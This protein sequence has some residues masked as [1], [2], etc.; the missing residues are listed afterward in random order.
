VLE[1][2][3]IVSDVVRRKVG[4]DEAFTALPDAGIMRPIS[5]R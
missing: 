3:V 4:R 5:S 2:V 1:G